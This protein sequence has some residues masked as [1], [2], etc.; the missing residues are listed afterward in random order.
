MLALERRR[1]EPER[2]YPF[3]ELVA[4]TQ[5]VIGYWLQQAL[6]NAGLATPIVTLVTQTVVNRSDPAFA[7]PTSSSATSTTRSGPRALSAKSHWTVRRDGPVAASGRLAAPAADRGD[8]DGPSPTAARHH[9][10]PCRRQERCRS[11]PIPRARRVDAVV[12]KDHVAALVA[13]ALGAELL[14]LLTDVAGVMTD[15]GTPDQRLISNVAADD[16]VL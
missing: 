6:A 15:F 3:S 8:R 13:T 11:R 5:G 14:V 10:D 16:L 2:P 1:R 7:D 12:D 9:R 4:E